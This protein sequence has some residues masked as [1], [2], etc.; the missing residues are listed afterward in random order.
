MSRP[1]HILL[2]TETTGLDHTKHAILS[3]GALPLDEQFHL[4]EGAPPFHHFVQPR[5]GSIVDPGAIQVNGLTWALDPES[6]GYKAATPSSELWLHLRN[7]IH[8]VN[9]PK[10]WLVAVGWNVSFDMYFLETLFKPN[11]YPFHYNKVDFLSVCRYADTRRGKTRRSYKLDN[12]VKDFVDVKVASQFQAH[13]ALGDCYR[14]LEIIKVY[15][16]L[17]K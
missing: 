5:E 3:L 8:E 17:E 4:I 11:W 9:L 14:T 12:M 1:T 16:A 13:N 15:Q 2:D 7:Y 6:P 10:E